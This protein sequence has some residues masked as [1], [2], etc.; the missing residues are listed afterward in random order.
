MT[1]IAQSLDRRIERGTTGLVSSTL[2]I[3]RRAALRYLGRRS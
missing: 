1:A 2:T 3:T